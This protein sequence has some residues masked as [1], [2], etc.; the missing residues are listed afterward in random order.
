MFF[1]QKTSRIHISTKTK[2]QRTHTHNVHVSQGTRSANCSKISFRGKVGSIGITSLQKR[3]EWSCR[4][5]SRAMASEHCDLEALRDFLGSMLQKFEVSNIFTKIKSEIHFYLG[6]VIWSSSQWMYI[7]SQFVTSCCQWH[8]Q[9]GKSME[10]PLHGGWC[11]W[12]IESWSA[13]GCCRKEAEWHF[14]SWTFL[15]LLIYK[16]THQYH[17]VMVDFWFHN[18]KIRSSLDI[19]CAILHLSV[20]VYVIS[21]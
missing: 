9:H 6:C 8:F 20:G 15:G 18:R 16:K 14:V 1:G 3:P 13:A 2:K 5:V 21:R 4:R 12:H 19:T 7:Y 10:D 17:G 11:G